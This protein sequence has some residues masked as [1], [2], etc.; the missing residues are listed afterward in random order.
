[1]D[2]DETD[3]AT[4]LKIYLKKTKMFLYLPEIN[5]IKQHSFIFQA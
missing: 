2:A 3:A 4:W 1:M 5:N